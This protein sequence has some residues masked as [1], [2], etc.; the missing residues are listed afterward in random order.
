LRRP[1][2]RHLNAAPPYPVYQIPETIDLANLRRSMDCLY[3][4]FESS[5]DGILD[6]WDARQQAMVK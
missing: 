6:W 2:Y 1:K 4:Y 3:R 5:Y